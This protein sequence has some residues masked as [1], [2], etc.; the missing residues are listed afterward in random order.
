MMGEIYMQ[1]QKPDGRSNFDFEIGRWQV[2]HRRLREWLQG[3]NAWEEFEGV[4]V[5]R[6]LLGGLGMI[7]EITNQHATGSFQG[8]TIA[9]LD[10]QTQQWSIVTANSLQGVFTTPMIG[11]FSGGIGRFYAHEPIGGRYIF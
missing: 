8:M 7:D 1:Q 10:P 11:R 4:S 6:K 5:A 2:H 3:S 9:V